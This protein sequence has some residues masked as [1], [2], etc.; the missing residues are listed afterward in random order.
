[1]SDSGGDDESAERSAASTDDDGSGGGGDDDGS[2]VS[3]DHEDA[4]DSGSGGGGGGEGAPSAVP[5]T[6]CTRVGDG[7]NLLLW[8][9]QFV[10]PRE[11]PATPP[12][13]A[14]AMAAA[15]A[16]EPAGGRREL[17][18]TA[19]GGDGDADAGVGGHHAGERRGED[20]FSVCVRQMGARARVPTCVCDH[21][22]RCS[23]QGFRWGRG[24]GTSTTS[25]EEQRCRRARWRA[26][27]KAARGCIGGI[28]R[29]GSGQRGGQHGTSRA[30][31]VGRRCRERAAAAGVIM[32]FAGI[33]K[34]A[35]KISIQ[36]W[37]R[38]DNSVVPLA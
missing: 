25:H 15:V 18:G 9:L 35:F 24:R 10:F 7:M 19:L 23:P 16:A 26:V 38:R 34:Y 22:L 36:F 17:V 8:R 27:S 4:E 12:A 6:A 29:S 13:A 2:G 20:E 37:S 28:G 21:A 11:A 3:S 31:C 33:Y 32:W 30:R 14:A 5:P 1:M